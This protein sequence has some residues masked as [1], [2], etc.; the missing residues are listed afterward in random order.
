MSSNYKLSYNVDMV[1]VIDCTETMD[2]IINIVKQRA[3]HFY[4]DVQQ[5]M[6]EANKHIDQL[7]VRL[8][9]FRDYAAYDNEVRKKLHRNE[10]MMVT[11]F[12]TLPAE[13][14]KLKIC[15]NSLVPS[16]GGDDDEDGLEA[17]AYAIR[18][19]WAT[20][21]SKDRHVIVLWT[22]AAPHQLGFGRGSLSYPK[23]MAS[24]F[25]ELTK[26]WGDRDDPGFMPEQS[27]KRLIMFAPYRGGWS[28]ISNSWDNVI[29]H[30]SNA[31]DGLRDVDYMTILSCIKN[32]IG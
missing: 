26:W 10:P 21:G 2:N 13:A 3:L 5:T 22:D 12:F 9:T 1:F 28:S 14:D 20:T 24:N 18:S 4:D 25:D 11:E 6:Q 17:L 15:V 30:K 7:R 16:G 8:V 31:G 29:V 27:A 19:N 23:G 32:T